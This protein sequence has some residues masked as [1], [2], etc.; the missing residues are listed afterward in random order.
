MK[1]IGYVAHS[2]EMMVQH[3]QVIIKMETNTIKV[4][5]RFYSDIKELKLINCQIRGILDLSKFTHLKKLDCTHNEITLIIN[6]PS[7]LKISLKFSLEIF[8]KKD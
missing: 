8:L 6:I 1:N 7:T 2:I 3:A 4:L 5:E